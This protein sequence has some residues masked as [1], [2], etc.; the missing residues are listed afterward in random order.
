MRWS[1][2]ILLVCMVLFT[3]IIFAYKPF[4]PWP[5]PMDSADNGVDSIGYSVALSATASSGK[6][7]PFL[8][9]SN[10]N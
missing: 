5:L 1:K 2:V 10:W 4:K 9:Y 3:D 7:A 8:F 6:N